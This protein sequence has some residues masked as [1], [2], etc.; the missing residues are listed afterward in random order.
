MSSPSDIQ[1]AI[2]AGRKATEALPRM[3]V[4]GIDGGED[5]PVALDGGGNI[6]LLREVAR[7]S[8]AMAPAP[9]RARGQSTHHELDSFIACCNRFKD[10]GS[11]VFADYGFGGN[12]SLTAVFDYGNGSAPRWGQH[13]AIYSC[14][15]SPEWVAWTT[16]DGDDMDQDAFADFLERHAADLVAPSGD[17]PHPQPIRL[18]EVSRSLRVHSKGTFERAV[19]PTTGEYSMVNKVENDST[20]TKIPA[21][22]LI[23]V[24]VFEAGAKYR[25]EARLRFKLQNGR[26]MFS[27]SLVQASAVFRDAFGEVRAKVGEAT[28]LPVFAGVPEDATG[29]PI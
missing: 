13:R 2:D 21:S 3:A 8:L 14:P 7:A 9:L 5:V 1:A 24:A 19:N 17:E 18:M 25:V 29:L 22:F 10:G 11:A 4:S 12:P 15:L 27:Y 28:G 16:A 6:V 23:G 26:P 20:S